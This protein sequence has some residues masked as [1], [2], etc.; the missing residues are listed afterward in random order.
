M[1]GPLASAALMH[2]VRTALGGVGVIAFL[3][4]LGRG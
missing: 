3:L 2:S 1:T 4:A